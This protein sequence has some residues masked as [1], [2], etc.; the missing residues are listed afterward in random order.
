LEK[1]QLTADYQSA[2]DGLTAWMQN[3]LGGGIQRTGGGFAG[4]GQVD[5]GMF[6]DSN[7]MRTVIAKAVQDSVAPKVDDIIN[8]LMKQTGL[9]AIEEKQKVSSSDLGQPGVEGPER[10]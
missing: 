7:E 5:V 2:A 1:D 6:S 3:T 10:F 9:K 4:G 8:D